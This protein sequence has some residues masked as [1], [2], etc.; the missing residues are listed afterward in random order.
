MFYSGTAKLRSRSNYWTQWS[1]GRSTVIVFSSP[2]LADSDDDS[3]HC[4]PTAAL[5][6]SVQADDCENCQ[7]KGEILSPNKH[8]Q[9]RFCQMRIRNIRRFPFVFILANLGIW[10]HKYADSLSV[11]RSV[12]YSDRPIFVDD[13]PPNGQL[14][15][16]Q[17]L[18]VSS[19]LLLAL[20]SHQILC[21]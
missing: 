8:C 9:P 10:F 14:N 18:S 11:N 15:K 17:I 20:F 2:L 6:R 7:V 5:S 12:I 13:R 3:C 19:S 16:I 1:R 4:I 21:H